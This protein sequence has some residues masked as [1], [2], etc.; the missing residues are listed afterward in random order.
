MMTGQLV[1]TAESLGS[2]AAEWAELWNETRP[3]TPFL[4]PVFTATWLRHFNPVSQPEFLA[5]REDQRLVGVAALDRVANMAVQL[6]DANV[7]DYA[8]PLAMP[9]YDGRVATA[10]LDW[11][12]SER[13]RTW[14]LWGIAS[15]A[16]VRQGISEAAREAG[17]SVAEEF[18]A[19]CPGLD[20]PA[21]F[22]AYVAGL[23]KHQRH[24]LRR[25][26]RN[27]RAAGEV[28][29]ESVTDPEALAAEMDRFLEMMRTSRE[30][31]DAFLTPAMEAFSRDLAVSMAEAGMTRLSTLSL[32]NRAVAMLFCFE[33]E[34]TLYLYNSG[35]ELAESQLAVGL[36]SKAFAIEDAIARGKRRFDFLRG[37]EEYKRRLGGVP[38]EVL[39]IHLGAPEAQAVPND[40]AECIAK[41][42]R[43]RLSGGQPDDV[44]S[45]S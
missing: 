40:A 3:A 24:E 41:R 43:F 31:K 44:A 32:D 36:L 11:L 5:V 23:P 10:L 15:G 6:G 13:I 33:T 38:G 19:V 29:F 39:R 7:C 12:A 4:H 20:L 25:K 18:E 37:D 2:L 35:F 8:G 42:R 28:R 21:T 17:W 45:G 22:D 34:D 26:L 1:V 27:L 30:D 16:P 9:G 14:T